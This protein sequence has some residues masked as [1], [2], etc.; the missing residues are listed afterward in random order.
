MC[1]L[2]EVREKI[3]SLQFVQKYSR[4]Y[5]EALTVW[6]ITIMRI[7]FDSQ[8]FIRETLSREILFSFSSW[9]LVEL[10]LKMSA[11]RPSLL[12]V[13]DD[14]R[15][16]Y[17][18]TSFC[19]L[20]PLKVMSCKQTWAG[21][22]YMNDTWIETILNEAF[23]IW[24]RCQL[25]AVWSDLINQNTCGRGLSCP[26]ISC[27][28]NAIYRVWPHLY[29]KHSPIVFKGHLTA[30][31]PLLA[32]S[33]SSSQS[34]RRSLPQKK[35]TLKKN[36]SRK[37]IQINIMVWKQQLLSPASAEVFG[38]EVFAYVFLLWRC[39]GGPHMDIYHAVCVCFALSHS[40]VHL[41]IYLCTCTHPM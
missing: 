39:T 13:T 16:Q 9:P 2:Q 41:W 33:R 36:P 26:P 40:T 12:E 7:S 22:I 25:I 19:S 27:R 10:S 14:C 15:L 3:F 37:C 31:L 29:V 28:P 6:V 32:F 23:L 8:Q 38:C 1:S 34:Y 11:W 17:M 4:V 18:F 21:R 24:I 30:S 20:L 5:C 35:K